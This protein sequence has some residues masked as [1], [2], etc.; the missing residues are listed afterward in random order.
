MYLHG[1]LLRAMHLHGILDFFHVG[2]KI[3]CP[4]HI[5]Y[6]RSFETHGNTSSF[7]IHTN[8]V[9]ETLFREFIVKGQVGC[10]RYPG[11]WVQARHK[12]TGIVL[13]LLPVV[14]SCVF[15]EPFIGRSK[16]MM[17]VMDALDSRRQ[18]HRAPFVVFGHE[19]EPTGSNHFHQVLGGQ[20]HF[21]D[22]F[23][24]GRGF[25]SSDQGPQ[26]RQ[27]ARQD[28]GFNHFIAFRVQVGPG[29]S[30]IVGNKGIGHGSTP[31]QSHGRLA[32]LEITR[33]SVD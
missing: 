33:T 25:A 28:A 24:F 12:G 29:K 11:F 4:I 2:I 14:L 23:G 1:G 15:H 19:Q 6:H 27:E 13:L 31:I 17:T 9:C 32:A 20:G 21:H 16:Q 30:I 8:R 5:R 3:G 10:I 7:V 26:F 22:G 18:L